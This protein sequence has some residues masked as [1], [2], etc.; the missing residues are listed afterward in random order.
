M[1]HLLLITI[2][3]FTG[4]C[5]GQNLVFPYDSITG[6]INYKQITELQSTSQDL[7]FSNALRWLE[8]KYKPAIDTVLLMDKEGGKIVIKASV[9]EALKLTESNQESYLEHVI[10]IEAKSAKCRIQVSDLK[11][12]E[13]LEATEFSNAGWKEIPI[14]GIILGL[15]K[16][17]FG[18]NNAKVYKKFLVAEDISIKAILESFDQFL[19]QNDKPDNLKASTPDE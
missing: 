2:V 12:R 11:F 7:A 1:R 16:D 4:A 3:L 13:Y 15:V 14:E 8:K 5:F 6:R 10:T 19:V 17:R 9:R 18:A